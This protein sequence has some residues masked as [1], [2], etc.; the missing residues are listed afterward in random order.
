[1]KKYINNLTYKIIQKFFP[2]LPFWFE[3]TG[4]R[5]LMRNLIV[6]KYAEVP[7]FSERRELFEFIQNSLIEERPINYLEFGVW[8]GDSIRNWVD[9]NKHKDS[10]F[11]GFDTFTGLPEDWGSHGAG[12]F[13]VDGNLPDINDE[14]LVFHKGLFQDTLPEFLDGFSPNNQLVINIVS[15]IYSS[16]LYC[17]TKLDSL[18]KSGTIILFDEFLDP[19]HEFSALHDYSRSYY[20]N[21]EII[22]KCSG[23]YPA[24]IKIIK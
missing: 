16:A 5:L 4:K 18:I 9:I 10:T 3:K 14:R 23:F 21:Y 15:D 24:V 8:K 13:D 22:A 19:M 7:E 1:M 12:T 20:R 6:E 2:S 17:L 11:D